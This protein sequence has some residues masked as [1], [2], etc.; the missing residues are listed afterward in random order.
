MSIER[1]GA[2]GPGAPPYHRA[3]RA[4]DFVFVSGQVP[5]GADGTLVGGGIEAQTK[6]VIENIKSALAL[7]GLGLKDVVKTTVFIEDPR[8]F[9]AFNRVY[10]QYFGAA[11]PARSTIC[12]ALVVDCKVEIEAIAYA[13]KG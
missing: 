4:G 13:S 12:T 5:A 2:P 6:Q 3:V 9:P 10:A 1:F 7:S 11:L 8:D